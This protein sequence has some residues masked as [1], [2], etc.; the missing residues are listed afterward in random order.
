MHFK[1]DWLET[2]VPAGFVTEFRSE[3]RTYDYKSSHKVSPD[4]QSVATVE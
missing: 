3:W 2:E 1:D 4:H